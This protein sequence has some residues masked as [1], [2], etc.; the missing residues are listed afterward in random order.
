M[1][2]LA[3]FLLCVSSSLMAEALPYFQLVAPESMDEDV[4]A[5][6]KQWMEK[7]LYYEVKLVRVKEWP[8]EQEAWIQEQ[9]GE[10]L[11]CIGL[12]PDL[13]S[14]KHAWMDAKSDVGL[15]NTKILLPEVSEKT[16]RR[17]DRQ[18]I[19]IVG[20]SLD[21]PPQPI[22]FCALYPYKNMEQLD[23]IGRGFSPPAMAQY[24]AAL[25]SRELPLSE[26]AQKLLPKTNTKIVPLPEPKD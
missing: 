6:A 26:Q 8:E 25:E 4:V 23:Q 10:A 3:L 15:V 11:V 2:I 21:I 7:N 9:K 12:S 17:L 18:L 20:F 24:R 13:G 5:R 16:L 19:R 22:P 1:R 14:D